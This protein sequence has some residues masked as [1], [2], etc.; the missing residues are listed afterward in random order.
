MNYESPDVAFFCRIILTQRG[1]NYESPDVAF[2]FGFSEDFLV[3]GVLEWVFL[4]VSE[5]D[6]FA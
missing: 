1:M 5:E 3:S 2:F 6:L 4:G